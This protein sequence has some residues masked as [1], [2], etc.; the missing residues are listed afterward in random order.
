MSTDIPLTGDWNGDGRSDI[1]VF[2]PSA[3]QF[4]LNSTPI[5]RITYGMSTDIPLTGDWNGDDI[6]DIGVF[7]PSA[8][9][10][11]LNTN[12]ITRITY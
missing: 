12:P 2:R 3:R 8:R 10:F 11:I 5:T 9:Q 7:R 6:S 4:I 1:G